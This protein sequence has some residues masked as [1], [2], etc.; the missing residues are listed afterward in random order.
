MP[1]GKEQVGSLTYTVILEDPEVNNS[2]IRFYYNRNRLKDIQDV[3]KIAVQVLKQSGLTLGQI[4]R[5]TGVESRNL[6]KYMSGQRNF[7]KPIANKILSIFQDT[8]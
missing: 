8:T 6:A 3:C 4:E 7:S 5:E 2:Y 1:R